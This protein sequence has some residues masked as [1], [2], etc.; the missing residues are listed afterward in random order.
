MHEAGLNITRW[1]G[2]DNEGMRQ[3]GMR[4]GEGEGE[5]GAVACGYR[6]GAKSVLALWREQRER[7]KRAVDRHGDSSSLVEVPA[8]STCAS[9]VHSYQ[10]PLPLPEPVDP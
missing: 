7:T 9:F 10:L 1:T 6:R 8:Q 3:L 4:C 2:R 5:R